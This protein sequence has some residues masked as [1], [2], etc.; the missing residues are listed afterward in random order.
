MMS[1]FRQLVNPPTSSDIVDAEV[2]DP[3]AARRRDIERHRLDLQDKLHRALE[4][5]DADEVYRFVSEL[6]ALGEPSL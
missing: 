2:A 1:S 3:D 5:D 4:A 6:A